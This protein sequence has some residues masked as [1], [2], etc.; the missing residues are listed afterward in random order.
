M[1]ES[2]LSLRKE[3]RKDYTGRLGNSVDG[4][5]NKQLQGNGAVEKESAGETTG[6]GG[7]FWGGVETLYNAIL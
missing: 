5:G 3:N 1:G 6:I 4:S 7:E 2:C